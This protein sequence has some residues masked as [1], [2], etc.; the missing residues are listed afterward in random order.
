MVKNEVKNNLALNLKRGYSWL[1]VFNIRHLPMTTTDSLMKKVEAIRLIREKKTANTNALASVDPLHEMSNNTVTKSHALTRAYYRFGLV[2]KR[3]MEALISKLHPLR[4]DNL[5]QE[6]ELS[7]LEYSRT[8]N[9]S[10][11]IAYRDLAGAVE[12]LMHRVIT[13]DRAEN[14]KGKRAFTLMSAAEYKTDEGKISCE[15]NYHVVPHLIGMRDKFSSYPLRDVVNFSSSYTWRFYELLAS[16]ADKKSTLFVGWI[17][18]QS[19]EELRDMLGVPESYKWSDF[20]KQLDLIKTELR[21]KA[22]IFIH[23]E[24]KKTGRKITHLNIQFIE[25][26]QQQLPLEGGDAK[27]T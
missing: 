13:T 4:G 27:K 1:S 18:N 19:V 11:K 26:E 24:R 6:I 5:H 17:K 2:E 12:T 8:Y 16:W 23:F 14:K 21:E 25:D 10:E 3:C 7:A 15:F 22:N 20:Q 9:V